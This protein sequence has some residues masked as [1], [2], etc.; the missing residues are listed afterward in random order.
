MKRE[1]IE[2][3]Y[4]ALE[5]V[6]ETNEGTQGRNGGQARRDYKGRELDCVRRIFDPNGSRSLARSRMIHFP[7][8]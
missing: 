1:S 2:G 4:T 7:E 8:T 3:K 6:R 5:G